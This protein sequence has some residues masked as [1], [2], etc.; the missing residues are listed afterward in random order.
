MVRQSRHRQLCNADIG[1]LAT[2]YKYG[3]DPA[4]AH[5]TSKMADE[6]DISVNGKPISSLRVVDLK[7]EC[8]KRGL[9]K[10][11]SKSQLVER[12]KTVCLCVNSSQLCS[13]YFSI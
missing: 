11:G 13:S 2:S 3:F 8:D 6:E 4:L 10:S 1:V 12:L 9:S 5:S 7:K